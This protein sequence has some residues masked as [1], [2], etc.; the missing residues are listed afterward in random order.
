M[1]ASPPGHA[2]DPERFISTRSRSAWLR[3]GYA[4]SVSLGTSVLIQGLS[5]ISGVL[6][7][8]RLGPSGR[9][10]LATVVVWP[11]VIATVG[12][13]SISDAI[14]YFAARGRD[15][16]RL[17]GSGL[18][19]ATGQAV[20][21]TCIAALL[22]PFELER[23][24]QPVTISALLYLPFISLY[25]VSITLMYLLN[26]LHRFA[27]FNTLRVVAV[28]GNAMGIL[29]L[30]FTNDV[31]VT[32]VV[33]V[34]VIAAI[35]TV[36]LAVAIC[37]GHVTGPPI[38]DRGTI[39]ELVAFG[40]RSH[41]STLAAALNQRLDQLIISI[42]LPPGELGLYVV[43]VTLTSGTTLVG[44]SVGMLALPTVARLPPGHR[45]RRAAA[46]LLA[47]TAV[48]SVIVAAPIF[49]GASFFIRL[50][51]GPPFASAVDSSRV[52][53]VAGVVFSVNRVIATLLKGAGRP[54]DAGW[55]ELG[56][57]VVTVGGL[58]LFVP[59]F[60]I[61][62][63]AVVSLVAYSASTVWMLAAIL[64]RR[65]RGI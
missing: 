26:G 4:V 34:Y 40:T 9:G 64:K 22:I 3:P 61:I 52:L 65:P 24:A 25:L 32:N 33:L 12:S 42:I 2:Q 1:T 28:L 15:A 14:S 19:I 50:F 37:A 7:A 20:I 35:A 60:G 41:A 45:R 38:V 30:Y 10:A 47:I 17:A 27:A 51:F 44:S 59:R 39:G 31:T 5:V 13:L 63:A 57:L 23:Y 58:L 55:A 18:V 56:A 62:G 21:L 11:F 54:M 16:S 46:R 53:L 8:R 43:A 36:A 48:A 6:L 29:G 49:L